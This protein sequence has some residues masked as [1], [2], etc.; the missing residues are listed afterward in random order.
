MKNYKEPYV[1]LEKLIYL[2]KVVAK[3][4]FIATC[5]LSVLLGAS[6][7]CNV[8]LALN[9]TEV[10]MIADGNFESTVAQSNE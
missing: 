4:W 8:Y 2:S 3:P 7:A 9:G 10:A 5:L 6:L 1:D